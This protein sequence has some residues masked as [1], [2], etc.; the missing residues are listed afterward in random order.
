ML[1]VLLCCTLLLGAPAVAADEPASAP[2]AAQHR[3]ETAFEEFAADWMNKVRALEQEE[4]SK[5]TVKAGATEPVFTYRGYGERYSTELRSTGY[6]SAPFVG[7]LRYTEHVYSCQNM[8]AQQCSVAS[9][10]PVTELFR[11]RNGRWSY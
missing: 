6:A 10:V 5:P 1:R 2:D 11:Y 3:A 4:R 7:L 9:S 8:K